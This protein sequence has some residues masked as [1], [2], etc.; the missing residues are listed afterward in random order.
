M[1]EW[2][3]DRQRISTRVCVGDHGKMEWMLDIAVSANH[4]DVVDSTSLHSDA[5]V[6]LGALAVNPS[7]CDGCRWTGGTGKPGCMP[8]DMKPSS[9]VQKE[10]YKYR[11]RYRYKYND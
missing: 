11:Y 6:F 7:F 3:S 2:P 10:R 9:S 1:S 8:K 5:T 4:H